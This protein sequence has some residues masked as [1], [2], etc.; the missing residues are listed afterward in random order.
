[1]QYGHSAIVLPLAQLGMRAEA[2]VVRQMT[3]NVLHSGAFSRSC[4]EI[5]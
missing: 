1:M 3:K 2:T 5:R 4:V